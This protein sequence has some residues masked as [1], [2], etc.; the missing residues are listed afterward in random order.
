GISQIMA[1]PIGDKRNKLLT[2]A[3]LVAGSKLIE[4]AANRLND[5]KIRSFTLPADAI[6]LS[7]PAIHGDRDQ[8]PGMVLNVKPVAYITAVSVH[9][10]FNAFEAIDDRQWD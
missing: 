4:Q 10:Q 1:G 3:E 9:R 7:Y 6:G 2:T 5:V 8:C